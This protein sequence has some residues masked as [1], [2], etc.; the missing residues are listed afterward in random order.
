MSNKNLFGRAVVQPSVPRGDVL[1]TYDTYLEAQKVVDKLSKAELD[2]KKLSIVGNDLKTVE[3]VTGKLSYGRAALG[4][5]ASGAWLGV[6]V[7]LV[8][9]IFS[10]TPSIPTVVSAAL[11]GAGFGMIFGIATYGLNRRRRDFTS[12]HQ[13]IASN[14]QVIAE[15]SV[16]ARAREILGGRASVAELADVA[17]S[18]PDRAGSTPAGSPPAVSGFT[19]PASAPA[20]G[21]NAPLEETVVMPAPDAPDVDEADR[22]DR[23]GDAHTDDA[24]T[25]VLPADDPER[26]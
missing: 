6:F 1:G 24:Q 9:F 5:A 4:G 19:R 26:R 18:A 15:N 22:D 3:H 13:V 7:G 8:F 23:T 17:A 25:E 21:E 14:Y 2:I 12:T 11:I 20:Y 16:A 10:P